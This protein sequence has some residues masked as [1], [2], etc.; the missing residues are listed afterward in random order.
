MQVIRAIIFD[1]DGTL[2][3]S[4]LIAAETLAS[5]LP[6]IGLDGAEIAARYRGWRFATILS[7]LGKSTDRPLDDAFIATYRAA[8]GHRYERELKAFPG[9]HA[10]LEAL[11]LPIAIASSGPPEKIA[12]ALAI[13]GL[14]RFFPRHAYSAYTL[15]S[16][17][18]EPALFLHAA[19][20]LGYPAGDVLVVED[21][22]V[23]LEAARRAAMR[24][25]LHDPEGKGEHDVPR[26]SSYADFAPLLAGFRGAAAGEM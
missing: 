17:K 21:S 18:P 8:A 26:F 4:E 19:G 1:L 10:A 11:D 12:R 9:V 20:A 3:D 5:L 15:N 7:E 14:A 25:V 23:G 6:E 22:G 16:W 24:A 13:T 2:V